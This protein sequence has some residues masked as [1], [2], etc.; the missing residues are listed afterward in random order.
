MKAQSPQNKTHIKS[1]ICA[2]FMVAI[3]ACGKTTLVAP[4]KPEEKATQSV[5][6][7]RS[8]KY[9]KVE[10]AAKADL[11]EVEVDSIVQAFKVNSGSMGRDIYGEPLPNKRSYYEA[12]DWGAAPLGNITLIARNL[13]ALANDARSDR[14]TSSSNVDEPIFEI[15]DCGIARG[16]PQTREASDETGSSFVQG[17]LKRVYKKSSSADASN[18]KIIRETALLDATAEASGYAKGCEH[19]LSEDDAEKLFSDLPYPKW[20]GSFNQPSPDRNAPNY[21][22][23]QKE[24]DEAY[25]VYEAEQQ[26]VSNEYSKVYEQRQK[27]LQGLVYKVEGS[28]TS[29]GEFHAEAEAIRSKRNLKAKSFQPMLTGVKGKAQGWSTVSG[30]VNS[31]GLDTQKVA[32]VNTKIELQDY[33]VFVEMTRDQMIQATTIGLN[34]ML[35]EEDNIK[36]MISFLESLVSCSGTVVVNGKKLSCESFTQTLIEEIATR[37]VKNNNKHY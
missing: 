16:R 7:L 24:Y 15:R 35:S 11:T 32:M 5:S 29:S 4:A 12:E 17:S 2:I 28:V 34:H 3:S 37:R 6:A 25:K 23:L 1:A 13:K 14:N 18:A 26:R 30:V 33:A 9:S 22:A 21:E 19:E 27:R 10:N 8:L 36:D 31:L 20:P